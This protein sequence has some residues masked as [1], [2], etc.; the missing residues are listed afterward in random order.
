MSNGLEDGSMIHPFNTVIEGVNA[1]DYFGT[2]RI[3]T[4]NYPEI[5]TIRRPMTLSS[6][7]GVVIIGQ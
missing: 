1:V 2:L 6:M 3:N 5:L 7:N 4:G